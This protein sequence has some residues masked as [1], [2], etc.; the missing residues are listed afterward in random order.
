VYNRTVQA[1]LLAVF[2]LLK[3]ARPETTSTPELGAEPRIL[4]VNT[5]ALG[6]TL[7]CT[8]AIRAVR[9]AFPGA[10]LASLVHRRQEALLRFNPHLDELILYPGKFKRVW[11]LLRDL[12][13]RSFDAAIILHAN[14]PD[15][16]PLV[17]LSAIPVRLG[18]A[19]SKF[20]FLLT[21]PVPMEE[22]S[23]FIA[24]RFDLISTLGIKPQGWEPELYL[25]ATA[26]V[27]DKIDIGRLAQPRL[28]FH[29]F[30]SLRR[31]TWPQARSQEFLHRVTQELQAT[32][33]IIGGE[34]ERGPAEALAAAHAGYVVPV[35]GR[36]SLLESAAL[37]QRCQAVISTDSGPLHLA[38][39]L[40]L[41]AVALMGPYESPYPLAANY[42]VVQVSLPCRD[43]CSWE[44][45]CDDPRCM[46]GITAD[47]VL[48]EVAELL[49]LAGNQGCAKMQRS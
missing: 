39:A 9:Q 42:R 32:V 30:A 20:A 10:H 49:A 17:Y 15:V 23:P 22:E 8:P 35:A 6:D 13:S 14:D 43:S 29:P 26:Q 38:K 18:W 3:A 48:S 21:H 1:I 12:R 27:Q 11:R 2:R 16:V 25:S 33:L 5:T 37:M 24:Q 36:L 34:N 31:K 44:K 41:K 46:E 19:A 7:M 40:D 45:K 4:L 47:M 28:V